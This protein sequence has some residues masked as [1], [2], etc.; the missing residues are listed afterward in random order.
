MH[1][2]IHAGGRKGIDFRLLGDRTLRLL[3][4]LIRGIRPA[5]LRFGPVRDRERKLLQLDRQVDAHLAD[6][7]GHAD[8]YRREVQDSLDPHSHQ[9]VGDGL[10]PEAGTAIIPKRMRLLRATS[11]RES[12]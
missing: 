2:E 10:R 4:H 7:I 5:R 3:A 6:V 9:P 12:R 11:G 1:E 8:R